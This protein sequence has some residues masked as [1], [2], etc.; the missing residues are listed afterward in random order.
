VTRNYTDILPSIALNVALN[1]AHQVRLSAA[2]TLAR[3]EY[4]ELSP[5]LNRDVLGGQGFQGDTSLVRT[6]INNFDF[7]WEWYPNPGELFSVAL[8]AKLHDKPLEKVEVPTSGTSV[9]SY[10]NAN[11]AENY[12]V[13]VELRKQL[14]SVADFLSPFSVFGNLTLMNSRIRLGTEGTASATNPNRALVGQAPYVFNG[15]VTWAPGDGQLS[16]TGLYNRVGRRINAAGPIPLPDIYEMPRDVVDLSL[17]FPLLGVLDARIDAKNLLD[18]P[19]ELR[20]GQVS[21][22][23]YSTGTTVSMGLSW[24]PR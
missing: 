5:I 20:Q 8:F 2:R 14:L 3:P 19:F 4:R 10:I 1:E 17:R 21:R 12:G 13:E 6:L 9:M 7:R 24:K 18:S 11:T 16:L 15:G 22:L 23:S